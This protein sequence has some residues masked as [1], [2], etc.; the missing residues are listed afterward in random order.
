MVGLE[1]TQFPEK[2]LN[3]EWKLVPAEAMRVHTQYGVGISACSTIMTSFS[4]ASAVQSCGRQGSSQPLL[5]DAPEV[6]VGAEENVSVGEGGRA[7]CQLLER[8]GGQ[9]FKLLGI[10]GEDVGL[11]LRVGHRKIKCRFFYTVRNMPPARFSLGVIA[12]NR[13]PPRQR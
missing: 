3:P 9:Q 13:P 6:F 5:A 10:G 7:A 12:A 11:A 8:V 4:S 1:L 2:D